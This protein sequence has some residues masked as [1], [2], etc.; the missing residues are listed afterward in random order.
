M[1]VSSH[2]NL[3][4]VTGSM[5]GE[6]SGFPSQRPVTRSF[7]F[8]FH[9]CLNERLSKQSGRRRA[10]YD[11][12]VTNRLDYLDGQVLFV[13]EEWSK[14]PAPTQ[15][16]KWQKNHF[17]KCQ[18]FLLPD[19]LSLLWNVGDIPSHVEC[20]NWSQYQS[21]NCAVRAQQ[22]VNTRPANWKLERHIAHWVG[23]SWL[24]LVLVF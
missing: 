19:T 4:H 8:F 11:A 6:S 5:W 24:K 10:H 13:H 17:V 14:L 20:R 21:S 1:I 12:T 7:D 23:N 3:F 15:C 2:G 22:S 9:L 18:C 16:G